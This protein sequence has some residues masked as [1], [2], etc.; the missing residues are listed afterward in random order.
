MI[1][2]ILALLVFW[3][4]VGIVFFTGCANVSPGQKISGDNN[5]Q[6]LRQQLAEIKTEW[7]EVKKST[8]TRQT[9]WVNIYG[10]GGLVL[11]VGTVMVGYWLA[12]GGWNG[13]KSLRS[14]RGRLL[15]HSQTGQFRP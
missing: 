14:R 11:A 12:K 2:I 13:I 6:A 7:A 4:L 8:M 1:K 15:K 5:T 3:F 9:G 10:S